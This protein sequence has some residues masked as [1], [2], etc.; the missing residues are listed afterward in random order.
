MFSLADALKNDLFR[1]L[2]WNARED[3]GRIDINELAQGGIGNEALCI[4][5]RNLLIGLFYL[6]YDAFRSPNVH[7]TIFVDL[8]AN[9]LAT[10]EA[11]SIGGQQGI[12][13]GFHNHFAG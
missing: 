7:L 4:C 9:I 6:S 10:A 1:C 12:C 3:E 5:Q 13:Y 2:C 8:D 11:L